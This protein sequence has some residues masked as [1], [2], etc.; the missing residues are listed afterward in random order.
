MSKVT[1]NIEVTM[2]ER[3]VNHFCLM[4]SYMQ[5][6]GEVGH[7]TIVGFHA[8]GDGD[9]R[10]KFNI[11]REYELEPARSKGELLELTT[12]NGKPDLY[13]PEVLYDA[14]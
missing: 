9:F 6:C 13:T 5:A 3:W 7:S 8:D 4:L 11:D 2:E 12:I 10:P 14:G 1:F